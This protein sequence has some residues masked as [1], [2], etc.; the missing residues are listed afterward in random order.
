MS[1]LEYKLFQVIHRPSI[2][3]DF[4]DSK[5]YSSRYQKEID[6]FITDLKQ[7]APYQIDPTAKQKLNTLCCIESWQNSE[8]KEAMAELQ[9]PS[10]FVHRKHWE[11]ALGIV[12]MQ[13]FGKLNDNTI[14]IGVGSGKEL[15]LFYLANK[16]KHIYATDIY[17]GKTSWKEDAPS[18]FP[19]N[20]TKYAPFPYREHSLT[21]S[22]MNAMELRFPS[23]NFDVAFSFSSIEHFGGKNHSGALSSLREMERVLKPGGI[24]IVAT[25]YIINNK[26]HNEFFNEITIYSDLINNLERLKLV[27]PLEL[28]ITNDTL[29]TMMEYFTAVEWQHKS[30]EFKK[31]HPHIL[32]KHKDILWTS[33]MLVFQKA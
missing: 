4:I 1:N 20:P 33:V 7:H 13:R 16:I 25:E 11:W 24:A 22:R 14:A 2:L 8:V 6:E 5:L 31:N 30:N 29:R 15:I 9:T 19:E 3:K 10:G 27:E 18:D 26:K 28:R 12:S 23:E 17:E 21:I 32:L